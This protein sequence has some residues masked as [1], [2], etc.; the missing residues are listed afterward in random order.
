MG[1]LSLQLAPLVGTPNKN[2]SKNR[3]GDGSLALGGCRWVLRHNNQP[4]VGGSDRRDGGE[5]DARPGWSVWGGCFSYF[6]AAS[7]TKK[8][9]KNIIRR[10]P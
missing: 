10:R 7:S 2:A 1:S 9:Y 5:E 6:G 3:E 4:I 8:I